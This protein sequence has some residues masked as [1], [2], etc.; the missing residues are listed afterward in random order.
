MMP[1]I[2]NEPKEDLHAEINVPASA[3]PEGEVNGNRGVG[4]KNWW[5]LKH[6]EH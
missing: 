3:A 5:P 2:C 4:P 1:M 6:L